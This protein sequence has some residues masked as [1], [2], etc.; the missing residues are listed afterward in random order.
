MNTDPNTSGPRTTV[1][2]FGMAVLA[3]VLYYVDAEINEVA[4]WQAVLAA[5]IPFGALVLATVKAWPKR[6]GPDADE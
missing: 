2:V 3:L 5:A 6:K 1:Y 4:L